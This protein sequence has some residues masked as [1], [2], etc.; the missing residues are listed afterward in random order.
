MGS[1]ALEALRRVSK[2]LTDAAA[3][4]DGLTAYGAHE[5]GWFALKVCVRSGAAQCQSTNTR[6]V[7]GAARLRGAL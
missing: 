5:V 1:V 2:V 7:A 4:G 6:R 3:T